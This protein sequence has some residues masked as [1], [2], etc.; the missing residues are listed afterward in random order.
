MGVPGFFKWLLKHYK[1]NKDIIINSINNKVDILY[2]DANCLFHPQC[3]KV[4]DKTI[5]LGMTDVNKIE[6]IMM[7]RIVNYIDYLISI[8]SPNKVYI[9]VDGVAPMAKMSQQRERRFK[10]AHD[11]LVYNDIKK[12]YNRESHNIWTNTVI[13][14]GTE[15]MEKLHETLIKYVNSINIDVIYSSY[16]TVGEGEHKILQHIKNNYKKCNTNNDVIVIYG[17]DADLIFLSLA[18]GVDNIYLLREDC[19]FNKKKKD[20]MIFD[21]DD[22]INEVTEELTYVCI[23]E[24]KICVNSTIIGLIEDYKNCIYTSDKDFINDFIFLCY[25]LGNDFLPHI[26]S[27]DINIGGLDKLLNVY[28]QI[29]CNNNTYDLIVR[30]EENVQINYKF[31]FEIIGQLANCETFYFRKVL[32]KHVKY[33][34]SVKHV[35]SDNYENAIFNLEHLNNMSIEDP[36][37]LGEG[38]SFLW[39]YRYYEHYLNAKYNQTDMINDMCYEYIR[40]LKWVTEYYFNRCI[41]WE[42]AYPYSH[43][44]FISDIYEYTNKSDNNINAI[45]FDNKGPLSPLIQ[46]LAVLPPNCCDILP[47]SYRYLTTSINSPIIDMFPEKIKIDMINKDMYWKC[48]PII[49]HIDIDRIKNSIKYINL[50]KDERKRNYLSEPYRNKIESY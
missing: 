8:T 48:I 29:F 43:S 23:D 38:N 12:R 49:P 42:W 5:E 24:M 44:P 33:I 21:L 11:K 1:H 40:G 28:V 16:H 34:R 25:L 26:P 22:V 4:L 41:C 27:I 36:I 19:H 32:T 30:E 20:N 7:Q 18:S 15:F 31:L 9:A 3:F 37:R 6:D 13:T 46:L 39:K 14:P 45:S 50:Q 2:L 17:L 35:K 47:K 10:S